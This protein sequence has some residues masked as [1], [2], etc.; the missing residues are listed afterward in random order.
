MSC[1]EAVAVAREDINAVFKK[2][3]STCLG[4]VVTEKADARQCRQQLFRLILQQ[5]SDNNLLYGKIGNII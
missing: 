3:F 5:V 2:T 4:L 1:G